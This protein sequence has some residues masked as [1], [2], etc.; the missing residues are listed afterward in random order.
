M[1]TRNQHLAESVVA[2]AAAGALL[3]GA[4]WLGGCE[5]IREDR[6]QATDRRRAQTAINVYSKASERVNGLHGDIIRAFGQAN[7]AN[8]LPDYREAL[9]G[10]V[11][12]AMERFIERLEQMP[13]GSPELQR[14]HLGLVSA[15]R[16]ALEQI[17]VFIRDLRAPQDLPAFNAI[18]DRLQQGVAHYNRDLDGYYRRFRREL[19]FEGG[20]DA[21]A[22]ATETA[23]TSP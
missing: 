9:R 13:T 1:F 15:Y 11:V 19:R 20:K 8:N 7:Q 14:I 2:L 10:D 3:T 6:A 12:P 17:R 16:E 5:K 4:L 18:R 23:A 22:A 21:P